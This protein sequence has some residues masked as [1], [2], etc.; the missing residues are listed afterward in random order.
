MGTFVCTDC[1]DSVTYQGGTPV[2]YLCPDC[3]DTY[4]WQTLDWVCPECGNIRRISTFYREP[5]ES[6][7]LMACGGCSSEGHTEFSEFEV[8]V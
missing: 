7:L 2:R 4:D 6:P 8:R 1:G 5:D 3:S